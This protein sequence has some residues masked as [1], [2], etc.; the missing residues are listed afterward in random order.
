MYHISHLSWKAPRN[1]TV[2]AAKISFLSHNILT[3]GLLT[4][5]MAKSEE[6]YSNS[7]QTSYAKI[8]VFLPGLF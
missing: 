4:V 2:N 5:N 3:P 6:K 8:V 7:K 1:K